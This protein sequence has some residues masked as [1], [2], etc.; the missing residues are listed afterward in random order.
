MRHRL[1]G[2]T[3]QST[4]EAAVFAKHWGIR[5]R[6]ITIVGNPQLDDLPAYRP[7]KGTVVV[8]TSVTPPSETGGA[9]PGSE[10][11]M[12]TARALRDHGYRVRVGLHPRE[13]PALWSDFEIATEGTMKAAETAE[14]VV[15]IPGSI[16]PQIA[17]LGAPVV[18][19]TEPRLQVPEYILSVAT[20]VDSIAEALAAVRAGQKTAPDTLRAAVGPLGGSRA[21]LWNY[22][23]HALSAA[24]PQPTQAVHT[25]PRPVPTHGPSPA[26]QGRGLSLPR[27]GA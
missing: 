16:F 21:R 18:G 5:Q 22:W 3:A 25:T 17:A 26:R 2:A 27:T 12:D 4:A 15:G 10:L 1:V 23:R 7:V 8:A 6:D 19:I 20:P 9:A 13:D 14:V 11:L 24:A